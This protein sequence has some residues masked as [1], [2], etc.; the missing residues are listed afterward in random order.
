MTSWRGALAARAG[1][2]RV[3]R[4]AM[5]AAVT[6]GGVLLLVVTQPLALFDA[7]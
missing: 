3:R 6:L 5:G 1:I 7:A 4:R 2:P